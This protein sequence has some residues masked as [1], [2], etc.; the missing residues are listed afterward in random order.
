MGEA[1]GSTGALYWSGVA[2]PAGVKR[3]GH[4][5][6]GTPQEPGRPDRLRSSTPAGGP[7]LKPPL[8]LRAAPARN[9]SEQVAQD[10]VPP[11][12]GNEARR[13]GRSGVGAP[14]STVEAGELSSWVPRGGKGAPGRG[15]IEGKDDGDTELR[16]RLNET[17][18]DSE[19]GERDAGGGAKHP[20]PSHRH[21]L[22]A[23]SVQAHAHGRGGRSGRPDR[24]G[25]CGESGREP[26]VAHRPRVDRSLPRTECA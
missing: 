11:S 17:A 20:C 5:R 26:P 1:E 8:P 19:A 10:T 3:A 9:G 13:K 18:T 16:N 21:G 12:E 4:A 2:G 25:V 7:A 14:H 22:D 15:T 6:M 23:R 24:A